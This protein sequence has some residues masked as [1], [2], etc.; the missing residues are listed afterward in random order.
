MQI[1]LALSVQIVR[2]LK[3]YHST[4]KVDGFFYA[5]QIIEKWLLLTVIF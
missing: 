4:M 1:A 3:Y 2:Y 5:A